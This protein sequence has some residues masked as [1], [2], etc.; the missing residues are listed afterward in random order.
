MLL[1]CRLT[2]TGHANQRGTQEQRERCAPDD[3]RL[4]GSTGHGQRAGRIGRGNDRCR[5][6]LVAVG[7]ER[8]RHAL[9]LARE[10]EPV[11][12]GG[13]EAAVEV[14]HPFDLVGAGGHRG[15]A[16][17]VRSALV[18]GSGRTGN[19]DDDDAGLVRVGGQ[20]V[21]DRLLLSLER[22]ALGRGGRDASVIV[23]RPDD[24][25]L[26]QEGPVD[27]VR[28][29]LVGV[30]R[31]RRNLDLDQAGLVRE[32]V[33][34]VGGDTLG[35]R[36]SLVGDEVHRDETD[37]VDPVVDRDEAVVL[38][39]S[40]NH[41]LILI[42]ATGIQEHRDPLGN[43]DVA[44]R[45]LEGLVRVAVDRAV[46]E[47][48][49]GVVGPVENAAV[50]QRAGRLGVPVQIDL[51]L[52]T[53]GGEVVELRQAGRVG[54]ER[55]DELLLPVVTVVVGVDHQPKGD[56]V[57][58][59]H[60]RGGV[61]ERP[62]TTGHGNVARGARTDLDGLLVR[63][64]HR[65]G[66][67]RVGGRVEV[68][69]TVL[70]RDDDVG[71]TGGLSRGGCLDRVDGARLDGELTVLLHGLT[72]VLGELLLVGD[73]V[74]ERVG[75]GGERS[76]EVVVG[77]DTIDGQ[78]VDSH[79]VDD[80]VH[81][82]VVIDADERSTRGVARGGHDLQR[83]RGG[84]LRL[85]DSRLGLLRGGG[86]VGVDS[87]LLRLVDVR[88]DDGLLGIGSRRRGRSRL[89]CRCGLGLSGSRLRGGGRLGRCRG[90]GTG[91]VRGRRVDGRGIGGGGVIG[92]SRRTTQN[93]RTDHHGDHEDRQE[94]CCRATGKSHVES[95]H[96][97]LLSAYRV[98]SNCG[99][100]TKRC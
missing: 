39:V 38:A 3:R 41:H 34:P 69:D 72:R 78:Q 23:E 10:D 62:G 43:R 7:R 14:L 61:A 59:L 6:G 50:D 27:V 40:G 95:P 99:L 1:L 11:L 88:L 84:P 85:N 65:T 57:L 31:H 26:A 96:R 24:T 22:V 21:R 19:L 83:G 87:L 18:R 13:R 74:G 77:G 97:D 37:A 93:E 29:A 25:F 63:E 47:V 15:P 66:D 94:A 98:V 53:L 81:E 16:D 89:G 33:L 68:L 12:G 82:V 52:A 36:V 44:V 35:D 56:D 79:V 73:Q 30:G 92:A 54:C 17:V 45:D 8:E 70:R 2:T 100:C 9:L 55:S 32:L 67:D 86:L 5:A 91:R 80:V 75:A 48:L 76:A 71:A 4:N 58:R 28:S 46:S 20:L 49:L 51:V 90:I 42:D 60:H 64:R